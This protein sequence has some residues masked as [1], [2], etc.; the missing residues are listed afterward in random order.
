MKKRI[1]KTFTLQ[2]D[3]SDCGVA[4]LSSVVRYHGGNVSLERLRELSGTSTEGTTLLGLHQAALAIGFD[5]EGL[6]ADSTANL[7]E[8]NVPA[9]LLV[10]N[11]N[12]HPHYV[13]F[14][15]FEQEKLIVGDPA[16]G[17]V[18]YT[19]NE[20]ESIWIDKVL[21]TLTPNSN[22]TKASSDEAQK[23]KWIYES[24]RA[25]A[26]H[27][28]VSLTLG[29]ITALLGLSTA[30]YSKKLIDEIIPASDKTKLVLSLSFMV[31]LL[32]CRSVLSYLRGLF[33]L[34]QGKD[35]NNRVVHK[36]YSSLLF[37]PKSF[38]D[39]RTIGDLTARMNDASRIQSTLALLLGNSLIDL[40]YLIASVILIGFYSSTICYI[41][42]VF[43][44]LYAL[45]A[46]RYSK[47]LVASQKEVM[48]SYAHSEAHYIDTLQGIASIKSTGREKFFEMLNQK[49]YARFQENIFKLGKINI[50]FSV[51]AEIMGALFIGIVFGLTA[52]I[53]LDKKLT[54][55]ELV[56]VVTLAG[57]IVPSLTRLV[58]ANIQIQEAKVV[59]DR[60]FEFTLVKPESFLH[61]SRHSIKPAFDS[62]QLRNVSFRFPGRAHLL[63]NISLELKKGKITV[64]LGESGCGKSTLVQIIQRFYKP[65]DGGVLVN[66]FDWNVIDT[67]TWRDIIG[68]VSQ[69]VKIFNGSLLY[70]I[71]LSD[72]PDD[73][74]EAIN[75]CE[76]VGLSAYFNKLPQGYLT[77][78]G[79]DGINL[80]G[81]Q[82]QLVGIAR[83][84]FNKPQLLL[85]DEVTSSLDRHSENFIRSL[86]KNMLPDIGVLMITHRIQTARIADTI[87]ILEDG[88]ITI[89]GTPHELLGFDNFYSRAFREISEL[90]GVG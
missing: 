71:C 90:V 68:V 39:T 20:L 72:L 66:G 21:L 59:V 58:T 36:F 51:V 42:L 47:P 87:Y 40:L 75:L 31:L 61:A 2:K 70:N 38:F 57:T 86:L 37:L 23:R 10:V 16:K 55:G 30:L 27:L 5:A 88:S 1:Q 34:Q 24:I 17:I 9:I 22:F 18:Y 33:I 13:V 28:T 19:C 4:C 85:L 67:A 56:A 83:A 32:M 84:L 62:L 60:M 81:G 53:T 80:S 48:S 35:F 8:I 52:F 78:I 54:V 73:V 44:P 45:L 69:D 26:G 15:G 3:Q 41:T 82:R 6:S 25:D 7:A 29:I 77:I 79:E 50:A 12:K 49:V 11:A 74:Q 89:S 14:Y 46:L 43:I 65:D 63:H 76:R 64:L